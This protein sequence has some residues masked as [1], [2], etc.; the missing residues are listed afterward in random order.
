MR[1]SREAADLVP[2]CALS[3]LLFATGVLVPGFGQPLGFVASAPLVWLAAR[4][5]VRAGMLGGLLATAVLLP[6]L[7]PPVTLIFAVEHVLPAAGLGWSLARGRGI[8]LPSAVAALIVTALVIGAAFLFATDAGRTPAALLEEQLRA[9]FA[10]LGGAGGTASDSAATLA[11]L[12]GLLAFLRRVLPA[13]ALVGIFLECALNTL[14]AARFLARTNPGFSGPQLADF[15]L[16]ERL[17]WVLIPALALALLPQG[18]LATLSLNA[19]IP[20]LF[21]YLLQGLSIT[22]HFMA[23]GG[24]SRFGRTLMAMACIF[25]PPVLLLPL[26]VGLLDFR[27]AFRTRFPLLP[28]SP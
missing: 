12:E 20:L 16:P 10:E 26:L 3:A 11:Q 7:P 18:T 17:V 9:A 15:A 28:P 6:L 23:R 21:A 13:I 25:Y 5:G 22:L 1:L 2:S 24:V 19:L 27:F 4:H 8:A 14:I